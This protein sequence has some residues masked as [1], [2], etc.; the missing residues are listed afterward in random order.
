[1][2]HTGEMSKKESTLIGAIFTLTSLGFL[3][4]DE[5]STQLKTSEIN[6]DFCN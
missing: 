6:S 5:T 1:M 4:L 3:L 2:K